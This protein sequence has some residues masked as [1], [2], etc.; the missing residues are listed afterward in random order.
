MCWLLTCLLSPAVGAMSCGEG[1]ASCLGWCLASAALL[2]LWATMLTSAHLVHDSRGDEVGVCQPLHQRQRFWLLGPLGPEV[3]PPQVHRVREVAIEVHARTA[4]AAA[5]WQIA[6][7]QQRILL[8]SRRRR[9]GIEAAVQ[10]TMPARQSAMASGNAS[11]PRVP[12]G[13]QTSAD[14]RSCRF[15]TILGTQYLGHAVPGWWQQQ[16]SVMHW[17]PA[18]TCSPLSWPQSH[19]DWQ[20]AARRGACPPRCA[21]HGHWCS[22]ADTGTLQTPEAPACT[23]HTAG[24]ST[25][26]LQHCLP[27]MRQKCSGMFILCGLASVKLH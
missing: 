21:V 14:G 3:L 25:V 11:N 2:P 16:L 5:C 27:C 1:S 20:M 9:S 8:G 12:D 7:K 26:C 19:Q 4:G 17:V 6:Y 15:S 24:S 22:G 13:C 18:C 10:V 23:Y